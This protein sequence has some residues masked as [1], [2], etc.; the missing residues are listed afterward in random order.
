M[1]WSQKAKIGKTTEEMG[2]KI[3]CQNKGGALQPLCEKV[4]EIEYLLKSNNFG[5]LGI[6]EAN[7]VEHDDEGD[8]VIEG[9]NV[10]W[11]N[12]L[13]DSVKSFLG[14]KTGGAP[15]TIVK[16]SGEVLQNPI[17]VAEEIKSAVSGNK[18]VPQNVVLSSFEASIQ[19]RRK[20]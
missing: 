11:D 7:F 5:V 1:V 9:Y 14:W 2:I 10:F 15:E 16:N 12:N 19:R 13:W 8:I 6:T 18:K 20:M 17:E 4:N 3:G